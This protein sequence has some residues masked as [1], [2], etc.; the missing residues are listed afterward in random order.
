MNEA[1]IGPRVGV[2]RTAEIFQYGPGCILKL[3]REGWTEAQAK[4]EFE[5]TLHVSQT[6]GLPVPK[7][8]EMVV[9]EG[10]PGIVF[11]LVEGQPLT[12][13]LLRKPWKIKWGA[14]LLAELHARVHSHRSD[15]LPPLKASVEHR[16]TGS[17]NVDP[18][19]K[20]LVLDTLRTVAND[21]TICHGDFHPDNVLVGAGGICII[22]WANSTAGSNIYDFARTTILLR[23]GIPEETSLLK[24]FL[25][26]GIQT[27]FARIYEAK[28][29][30]LVEVNGKEFEDW[31]LIAALDRLTEG[32]DAER[33][34]L[35]TTLGYVPM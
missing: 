4:N 6:T 24:R 2:G 12:A 7:V 13:L 8:F 26:R 32:I 27:R 22:D 31:K 18:N 28:Y 17:K 3:Y 14:R 5:N 33:N 34:A 21:N 10:R 30:S 25:I 9:Y 29:R 19:V 1:N 20:K 23:I 16:V 35:T 11:E 15:R